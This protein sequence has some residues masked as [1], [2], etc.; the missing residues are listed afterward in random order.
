MGTHKELKS[1]RF[2]DKTDLLD[3]KR[4]I[5]AELDL[6][7]IVAQKMEDKPSAGMIMASV[8]RISD[9]F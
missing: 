6:L 4:R 2:L 1:W 7:K 5:C 9:L 3:I 8:H